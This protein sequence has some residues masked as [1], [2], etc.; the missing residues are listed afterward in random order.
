MAA[1]SSAPELFVSL[2]DN[3]ITYPPKSLGVGTIVGSAIFNILVIIGLTACLSGQ[4][5][6]IDWRPLVRDTAWYCLSIIL[7][8]LSVFDREIQWYDAL[9]LLSGY[10]LYVI[11]C[12]KWTALVKQ[13]EAWRG[14]EV[15]GDEEE[16]GK[17]DRKERKTKE[18]TGGEKP[19]GDVESGEGTVK[20]EM[21]ELEV[22]TVEDE[23]DDTKKTGEF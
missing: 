1:G 6:L 9:I 23:E 19:T 8:I 16:D 3:V 15:Q 12:A 20:P 4:T 11:T 18:D 14:L 17:E 10:V 5:L 13:L 2:A 21:V 7:L 22:A